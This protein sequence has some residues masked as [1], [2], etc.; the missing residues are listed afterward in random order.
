MRFKAGVQFG[1][2]QPQIW[3]ALGVADQIYDSRKEILTVTSLQDGIHA[4]GISSGKNPHGNG[5]AVDL[6]TRDLAPGV[7]ASIAE[8]LGWKLFKQGFDIEL[9]SN[10]IHLE[11]DPK[12][13]R[14]DW[15][16]KEKL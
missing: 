14:Q 12:P 10:H 5:L 13:G 4:K 15:F 1:A 2:V 11:F 6:R 9:E 16:V 3:Y 7:A 8:E